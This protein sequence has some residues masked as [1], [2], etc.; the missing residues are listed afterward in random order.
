MCIVSTKY[1]LE[2]LL[3][4][5]QYYTFIDVPIIVPNEINKLTCPSNIKL[6]KHS[7]NY[8]YIGSAEQ[9]LIYLALNNK[10]Q[11]NVLYAA[12]TPC[13]RP[14]PVLDNT[15]FLAFN[16]LELFMFN[17]A[18]SN[19]SLNDIINHAFCFFSKFLPV[20]IVRTDIGYDI[21]S[22][23]L[24]IGSYGIRKIDKENVIVYGTGFADPRFTTALHKIT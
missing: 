19:D 14:E 20:S 18:N 3:Y 6:I 22:K 13:L 8:S 4:Y 24:E 16:K 23:D 12:H 17:P 10:L 15:H 2:A 11:K 7:S 5:Q 9:S 21:F 1:L